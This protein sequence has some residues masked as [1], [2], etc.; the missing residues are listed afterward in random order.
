M[1]FPFKTLAR[2]TFIL[3]ITIMLI[4]NSTLPTMV[5]NLNHKKANLYLYQIIY[6]KNRFKVF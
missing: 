3:P 5:F 2:L 6:N 1:E 4:A